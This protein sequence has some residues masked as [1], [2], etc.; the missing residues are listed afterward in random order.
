MLSGFIVLFLIVGIILITMEVTKSKYQ[1]PGPQIKYKYLPRTYEEEMDN[2]IY[3]SMVYG[4][5]FESSSPWATSFDLFPRRKLR[6]D[7]ETGRVYQVD[8]DDNVK[9]SKGN[10]YGDLVNPIAVQ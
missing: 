7:E 1:C 6:F 2:Y 10:S 9:K 4:N 3:P 8:E 5:M